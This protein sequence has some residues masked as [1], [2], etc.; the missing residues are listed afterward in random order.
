MHKLSGCIQ[1]YEM[2]IGVTLCSC[3]LGANESFEIPYVLHTIQEINI[4]TNHS[5]EV[6]RSNSLCM[7]GSILHYVIEKPTLERSVYQRKSSTCTHWS[8]FRQWSVCLHTSV[9][10]VAEY[11][12]VLKSWENRFT[13]LTVPIPLNQLQVT[14][15]SPTR[16]RTG[17]L[18]EELITNS[19]YF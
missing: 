2:S 3:M 4:R 8:C 17:F 1:H 10:H 11:E 16:A 15:N 12:G 13:R 7:P 9:Q 6:N 14:L 5:S 19:L 18:N